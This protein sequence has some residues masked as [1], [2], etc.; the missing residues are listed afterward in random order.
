M[1]YNKAQKSL[2]FMISASL[3]LS[4]NA[5][6]VSTAKN[7]IPNLKSTKDQDKDGIDDFSD[8]VKSARAQIGV[9]T[10]YDTKYYAAAFPPADRGSCADVIW[11]ALKSSGYDFKAL[12]DKDMRNS[13]QAY[14][15]TPAPDRNI[16]FRRVENIRIFLQRKAQSLTTRIIPGDL[17]NLKE[18]Q[19]GDIVTYAQMPGGLWHVAIISDRRRADGVP[20][21]IHNYGLGV[22]EDDYILRWPAAITG[23]FRWN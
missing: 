23:H 3:I 2:I 12:I 18:W 17:K 15:K 20:L 5:C 14:K 11:R 19:A 21:L 4:L 10:S 22:R 13:P 9:V 1:T 8:L 7:S 16:N 6:S